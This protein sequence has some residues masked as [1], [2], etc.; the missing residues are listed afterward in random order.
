MSNRLGNGRG[1]VTE[2]PDVSH[3]KNVDVTHE[4]SDVEVKSIAMFVFGLTLMTVATCFLMWAMFRVLLKREAEPEPAPMAMSEKERLPAEP[5]LQ[6]APGFG[7][8]LEKEV[9]M[10]GPPQKPEEGVKTVPRPNQLLAPPPKDPLW[11]IQTLREHWQKI[12]DQGLKDQSGNVVLPI[13]EAKQAIL[14]DGLPARTK[15]PPEAGPGWQAQDYAVDMPTAWSS[16]R[17]T[18]KRKQ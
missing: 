18:E 6:S 13:S 2:T 14:R 17:M 9:G 15:Q 1:N 3:I 16:G 11:E 7:S 8:K 10:N 4:E 5:R 12:L